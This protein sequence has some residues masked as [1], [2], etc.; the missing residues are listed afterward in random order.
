MK[1]NEDIVCACQ[2]I[3]EIG[4]LKEYGL[5]MDGAIEQ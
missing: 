5:L 2:C 1:P 4:E 3:N